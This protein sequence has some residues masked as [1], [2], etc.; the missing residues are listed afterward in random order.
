MLGPGGDRAVRY[1]LGQRIDHRL[2][3]LV[4]DV[5]RRG[6]DGRRILAIDHQPGRRDHVHRRHRAL[7]VVVGQRRVEVQ[8]RG[9]DGIAVG[10][11]VDAVDEALAL[12]VAFGEVDGQLVAL[13]RDACAHPHRL[14]EDGAVV[15]GRRGAG[16]DAIRNLADLLVHR[17][18]GAHE[19]LVDAGEHGLLAVGVEQRRHPLLAHD[20]G[21][22]HGLEI[23]PHAV[24]KAYVVEDQV[25]DIGALRPRS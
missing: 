15:V 25:D 1:R 21:A 13:D 2:H 23:D 20:R 6:A 12:A 7:V 19:H 4:A 8:D 10:G 5:H 3:H 18:F 9:G 11:R 24:A 14:I 16:V 17:P 22:D